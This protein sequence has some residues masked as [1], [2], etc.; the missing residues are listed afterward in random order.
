MLSLTVLFVF[1]CFSDLVSIEIT[2][3]GKERAG[4][5]APRAFVCLF[6]RVNFC[7]FYFSSLCQWLA[8]ACDCGIP[9]LMY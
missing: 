4:L 6:S 9:R 2:S 5:Y 3:L 7:H 1:V 8:A